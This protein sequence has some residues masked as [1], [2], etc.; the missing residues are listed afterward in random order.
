MIAAPGRATHFKVI[1]RGA[2]IDFGNE[3]SVAET[4]ETAILPWDANAT[5]A[6][7]LSNAAT[8]IVHIPCF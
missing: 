6:I 1:S 7:N 5:T 8:A 3:T 2:E 4:S